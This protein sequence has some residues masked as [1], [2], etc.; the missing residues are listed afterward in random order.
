MN[1]VRNS[2][3]RVHTDKALG[4]TKIS[5]MTENE[6]MTRDIHNFVR[7]HMNFEESLELIEKGSESEEWIDN[8]VFEI[9]LYETKGIFNK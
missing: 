3:G 5:A 6:I 1:T 9:W 4:L 2:A 8:L 7:G